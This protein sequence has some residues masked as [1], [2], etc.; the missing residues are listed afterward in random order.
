MFIDSHYE[1]GGMSSDLG[2]RYVQY[3]RLMQSRDCLAATLNMDTD[4]LQ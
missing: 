2:E 1:N 3:G 4:T